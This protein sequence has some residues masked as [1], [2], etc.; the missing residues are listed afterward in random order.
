M[1]FAHVKARAQAARARGTR[2][3]TTRYRMSDSARRVTG[4]RSE[5][6][7]AW[8]APCRSGGPVPEWSDEPEAR[9][10]AQ[11]ER[12]RRSLDGR[13]ETPI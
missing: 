8:R 10:A 12:A 13:T 5:E 4:G 3:V 6:G 2:P 7:P 11:G 9:S 1:G